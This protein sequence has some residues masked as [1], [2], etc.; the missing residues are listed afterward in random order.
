M[1][2]LRDLNRDQFDNLSKFCLDLAKAAIIFAVFSPTGKNLADV[3]SKILAI[4]SGI[5]L[6]SIGMVLLKMKKELR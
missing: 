5:A 1:Q 6:I 4:V 3:I 2:W